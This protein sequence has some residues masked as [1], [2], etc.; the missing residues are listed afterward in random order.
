M[1]LS[2][3]VCDRNK[4]KNINR[5]KREKGS[6]RQGNKPQRARV[7]HRKVKKKEEKDKKFL[8]KC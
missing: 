6:V 4:L 3:K 5:N 7:Y 1:V 2:K 8:K